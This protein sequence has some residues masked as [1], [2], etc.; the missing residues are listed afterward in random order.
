VASLWGSGVV[1]APPPA[2]GGLIERRTTAE[3]PWLREWSKGGRAGKPLLGR[4][5]GFICTPYNA[6]IAFLVADRFLIGGRVQIEG[7]GLTE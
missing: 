2:A 3:L 7:H 6:L 4:S 1:C 5:S